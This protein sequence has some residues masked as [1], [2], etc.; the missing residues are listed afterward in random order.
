M[1]EGVRG[2]DPS[3]GQPQLPSFG[4]YIVFTQIGV[5]F[6]QSEREHGV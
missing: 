2:Q 6:C 1:R 3:G 5:K 4:D